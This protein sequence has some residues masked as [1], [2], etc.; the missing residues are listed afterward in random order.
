MKRRQQQAAARSGVARRPA[1]RRRTRGAWAG[2]TRCSRPAAPPPALSAAR[3]VQQERRVAGSAVRPRPE[4]HPCTRGAQQCLA[5]RLHTAP[6]AS[7]AH[8]VKRVAL[9]RSREAGVLADGPGAAGVHGSVGAPASRAHEQRMQ[10]SGVSRRTRWRAF[11]GA[12]AAASSA[13]LLAAPRPHRQRQ[14]HECNRSICA[15]LV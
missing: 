11:S 15:H 7:S 14:R 3:W 4:A 5:M 12:A 8:L 10:A 6:P 1:A 2:Q 13:C 9:L